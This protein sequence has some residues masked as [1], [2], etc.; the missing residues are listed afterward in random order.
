MRHL[1]YSALTM[2][3]CSACTYSIHLVHTSDYSPYTPKE[4]VRLVKAQTEQFVILGITDNTDYV[5]RAY[6]KLMDQCQSGR[7]HG[8]TTQFSTM[9]GFFSWT[10]KILMQGWCAK[11]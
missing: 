1:F 6:E 5:D 3:L 4:S 2:F 11:S 9:H 7:I 8:I 10:N